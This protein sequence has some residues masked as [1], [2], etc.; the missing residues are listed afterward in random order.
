[1]FPNM[2]RINSL[3]HFVNHF[4]IA[5][6]KKSL[7]YD[8]HVTSRAQMLLTLFCDLNLIRRFKK[9]PNSYYRIYPAYTR[10]RYRTRTVKTYLRSSHYLTLS[11]KVLKLININTPYSYIILETSRGL[12]THKDAIKHQIGGRLVLRIN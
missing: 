2:T 12:M 6:S 3:S 5:T 7:C 1:M 9:L 11:L 4:K 8:V 10:Y